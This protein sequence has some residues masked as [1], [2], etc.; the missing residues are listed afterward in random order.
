MEN[1]LQKQNKEELVW[2][3]REDRKG[4]PERIVIRGLGEDLM[5]ERQQS[6]MDEDTNF[7]N[8]NRKEELNFHYIVE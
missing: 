2:P 7:N 4:K 3:W 6:L 5:A 8:W 1:R